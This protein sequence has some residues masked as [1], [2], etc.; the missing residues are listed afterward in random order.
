M[1][2]ETPMERLE[3]SP[4]A[5]D[6]GGAVEA[7]A[8]E[9]D[10]EAFESAFS[11]IYRSRSARRELARDKA[12]R[13]L[14][15]PPTDA[16]NTAEGEAGQAQKEPAGRLELA[17]EPSDR[18]GEHPFEYIERARASP[19]QAPQEVAEGTADFETVDRILRWACE[20]SEAE[21][22][23]GECIA[24]HDALVR[25]AAALTPREGSEPRGCPTPGACSCTSPRELTDEE[26]ERGRG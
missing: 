12:E 17:A 26:A 23:R 24:A 8:R 10:P 11:N 13:A 19:P 1:P 22:T 16:I 20:T 15:S 3:A 6:E 21:P 2:P 5:R 7:K 4:Q 9:I 14:S 18:K 25:L